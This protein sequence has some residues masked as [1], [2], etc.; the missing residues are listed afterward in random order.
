MFSWRQKVRELEKQ[1]ELQNTVIENQEKQIKILNLQVNSQ[2]KIIKNQ[3]EQIKLLEQ[4]VLHLENKLRKYTNE[5]TPSSKKPEW[6]KKKSSDRINKEKKPTGKPKGSNGATREIPEIDEEKVV[7]LEEHEAYLGQPTDYI[8]RIVGDIPPPNKIKWIRYW[9]AQYIDPTTHDIITA[10]HPDCPE[11][12]TFGPNLRALIVMLREKAKLSE[13]QTIE[14][15]NSLYGLDIAPGTIEAELNRTANILKHDYGAIAE[16]INNSKI[17]HSDET[18]QS[19]NGNN[20]CIF[21]FS[22]KELTY[23]FSEENKNSEQVKT[24]LEDDMNKVLICDGH[25]IY[26]WW[27]A[28][29][30][31]WGHATR[32]DKWLI[33]EKETEERKLLHEAISG[34][35]NKCKNIL[36]KSPPGVHQLWSVLYLRNR[37]KNIIKYKWKDEKCQKVANYMKNGFN[38]W[39][40]FMFV[41]GVEPTNNLNERDLRKHVMKR[42]NSGAFRSVKGLENH[43][44]LLSV[45]ETWRK[46]G[47]SVYE[48]L[49]MKIKMANSTVKWAA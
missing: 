11:E 41:K 35:F 37:L 9:L 38:N 18:G 32:K 33:N 17:K 42:K 36:D 22:T 12:G 26:S 10:T 8:E 46:M 39:F 31:C 5:N 25:S 20:W 16:A 1:I 15:L 29:Q 40:T 47:K 49:I 27:Y 2:D 48:T 6:E 19:L 3:E 4:H 21:C 14:L 34:T 7:R 44:I 13:K 45:I 43:C 23:F 24:R 30:R 28:K